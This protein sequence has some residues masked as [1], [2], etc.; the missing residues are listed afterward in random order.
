MH[1][2]AAARRQVNRSS[3]QS[4]LLTA[5]ESLEQRQLLAATPTI[6]KGG[7]TTAPRADNPQI[8]DHG[9]LA[10]PMF[11]QI[12]NRWSS[13]A[14][15][16]TG[17]TGSGITLTWS[18]VPDGTTLT[19]GNGEGATPSILQAQLNAKYGNQTVW[20]PLFQAAFDSWSAV[21]G[22]T[23][24]YEPN[25]DG[26]IMNNGVPGVLG[27][28]GDVRIGGHH[29]DGTSNVLAYNYFPNFGDMTLDTDE[30]LPGGFFTSTA[31]NSRGL[32]NVTAHEHGHG[33]G[34]NHV[35]PTNGTKLMEAFANNGF[36]MVQFD[37]ML[38]VQR[39]YG[40]FY[41]K[42][43]GNNIP[44]NAVNRG[45]LN[46]GSQLLEKLAVSTTSDQDWFKFH[47]DS[48]HNLSVNVQPFGPT[49]QQGPQGG[50]V[51]LFNASAQSNLQVAL[52]ASDGTTQ[53]ALVNTNGVG[54]G[55]IINGLNLTSGDY[56][57]RVNDAPGSTNAV[58]SYT[59]TT[60]VG[61]PQ[62][63]ALI[64]A[65]SPDP[66]TTTVSSIAINFNEPVDG[67]DLADL[68]LSRDGFAESLAGA[69]LTTGNNQNFTLGNLD[70][71]TGHIGQYTLTLNATGSGITTQGGGNPFLTNAVESWMMQAHVGTA[72]D[73]VIR[74]APNGTLT[75][76]FVNNDTATPTYS[77][78]T[79]DVS[80]W[81]VNGGAGDD[82]FVVDFTNGSPL[83]NGIPAG[84]A[85]WNGGADVNGDSIRVIGELTTDT[86]Q[87]SA[88]AI[89]RSSPFA[90]TINLAANEIFDVRKG[91]Y[92]AFSDINS[93][94]IVGAQTTVTLSSNQHMRFTTI[95][96][97]GLV[98]LPSSGSRL[99]VTNALSISG[100]GR[101]DIFN[102]QMI[103]NYSGASPMNAVEAM[104]TSARNG[105]S[106]TGSGL[107]SSNA[108]NDDPK[109]T[110]IGAI[111]STDYFSVYGAGAPFAGE[112]IDDTAILL[113][114]TYYGDTD[115]NGI[116]NFD[117]Y[118]RTDA[119]FNGNKSGWFNGDFDLNDTVNFDDYS[120]I[121]L[122]FNT[123]A[124]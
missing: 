91:V 109:N 43:A 26:L 11:Y 73:E 39:N 105:G 17:T 78:N 82:T 123:Q 74:L 92:S 88:T 80:I 65:V 103:V 71:L 69:T 7:K 56:F 98:R 51:S 13:T 94:L 96:T 24:V 95:N 28:R 115:F 102:N 55:E 45:T 19:N 27:T 100:T 16:G 87:M 107:I 60:T 86:F 79:S 10:D 42:G 83:P 97:G 37:D 122:A 67:F 4:S 12:G 61:D 15:G 101:L 59:L 106:W 29:I 116:V 5:I 58:Q 31:N 54:F 50:S 113:K 46:N 3:S 8:I 68:T 99:L 119:G 47:F 75:D 23:Y 72:A 93:G 2:R 41:E 117:D 35:D 14:S 38:A 36:D 118:S 22:I 111:E 62:A 9:G 90:P 53:L 57:I 33:L 63:T 112:N 124:E 76:V 49:Y 70:D 84:G 25:D 120:L 81:N 21:S 1:R 52:F 104:I 64:T 20:Q 77:F 30:F 110:G 18:F 48:S 108:R 32:R 121:D 89:T 34:F 6:G 66:R 40:D 114:Y 85:N 44:A